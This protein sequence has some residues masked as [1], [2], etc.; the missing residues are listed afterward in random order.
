MKKKKESKPK[1]ELDTEDRL[2][3][4]SDAIRVNKKKSTQ[5]PLSSTCLLK[6]LQRLEANSQK[7][8]WEDLDLSR[9]DMRGKTRRINKCDDTFHSIEDDPEKKP[10][11]RKQVIRLA[12]KTKI[13]TI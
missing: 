2:V 11:K 12:I 9:Q 8:V 13:T 4:K 7:Q 5:K 1:L 6:T 10:K 3:V